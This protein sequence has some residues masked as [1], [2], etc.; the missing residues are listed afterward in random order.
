[1]KPGIVIAGLLLC[2]C[3]GR[4]IGCGYAQTSL[5]HDPKERAAD[6]AF[7]NRAPAAG[8]AIAP[9]SRPASLAAKDSVWLDVHGTGV[10]KRTTHLWEASW[11]SYQRTYDRKVGLAIEYGTVGKT[12]VK[13]RL[14]ALFLMKD[15]AIEAH[16]RSITVSPGSLPRKDG[17]VGTAH[18]EDDNYLALGL[19]YQTGEKISGWAVRIV[20]EDGTVLAATA[21][22]GAFVDAAHDEGK[23][24][25]LCGNVTWN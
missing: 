12:I 6:E 1:M 23:W 19:R 9:I 25:A 10:A 17:A 15:R 20:G 21:S 18:A 2:C 13:A 7:F 11:G 3:S 16:R 14:E 24:Q 4:W 8:E 5:D 22:D